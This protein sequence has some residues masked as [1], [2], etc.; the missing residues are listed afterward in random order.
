VHLQTAPPDRP[1]HNALLITSYHDAYKPALAPHVIGLGIG[2]ALL[3][4]LIAFRKVSI[5]VDLVGANREKPPPT[6]SLGAWL[7]ELIAAERER[8]SVREWLEYLALPETD[9]YGRVAEHMAVAG[10][11]ERSTATS[12]WRRRGTTV[13]TPAD[14]LIAQGPMVLMRLPLTRLEERLEPQLAFLMALTNAVG[15]GKSLYDAI[16]DAGRQRAQSEIA[17]LAEPLHTLLDHLAAA[18][19]DA[20]MTGTR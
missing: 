20:A 17:N 18:V 3:A 11:M 1:V 15:L 7:H 4:E 8:L 12:R 16:D 10:Y 9:L 2:A 13:Y 19:A 5:R 6:D 14:P